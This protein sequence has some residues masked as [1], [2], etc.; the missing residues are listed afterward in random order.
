MANKEHLL[1]LKKGVRIWNEWRDENQHIIPD[2]FGTNLSGFDLSGGNFSDVRLLKVNL[3]NVNLIG[4]NLSR[5]NLSGANLFRAN[6]SKANLNKAILAGVDLS[7][8]NLSEANLSESDFH[9]PNHLFLKNAFDANLT[10]VNLSG[11]NLSGAILFRVNLSEAILFETNLSGITVARSRR[12]DNHLYIAIP[13]EINLKIAEQIT[14]AAV[15]VMEA[16]GF[17]LKQINEPIIGSFF[18]ELW[19]LI[20]NNFTPKKIEE[21]IEKTKNALEATYFDKPMA[22]AQGA[23]STSTAALIKSIEQIDEVVIRLDRLILVKAII[24]DK[25][26]LLTTTI[27]VDLGRLLNTNPTLLNHP[28]RVYNLLISNIEGQNTPPL[29]DITKV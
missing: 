14:N 8:A 23:I 9:G 16:I 15:E 13:G 20:K 21:N 3:S 2:L 7:E 27:T 5:A 10:K 26:V 24:D 25:T 18:K 22:E 29:S 4:A 28:K 12:G 19:F 11:A 1:I 17:K 6:L